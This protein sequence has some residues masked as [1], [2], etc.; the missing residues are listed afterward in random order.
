MKLSMASNDWD[1]ITFVFIIGYE[2]VKWLA[3]K[4]AKVIDVFVVVL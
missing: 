3:V 1:R 4:G 2:V